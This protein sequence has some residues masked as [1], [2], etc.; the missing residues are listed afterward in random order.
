[1]TRASTVSRQGLV[2]SMVSVPGPLRV[3]PNTSVPGAASAGMDSPVTGLWSI[4]EDPAVTVPSAG[5]RS[6]AHTSTSSP[7]M[8]SATGTGTV[9]PSAWSRAAAGGDSDIRAR[10]ELR[11]LSAT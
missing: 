2:I 6:P 4:H 9:V 10:I 7:G 11:A 3:P 1:M 8:R 5:S